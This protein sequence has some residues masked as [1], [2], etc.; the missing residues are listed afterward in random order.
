MSSKVA[1]ISKLLSANVLAQVI[2]MLIYPLLT[3]MYQPADF[4]LLNLFLTIANAI[5]IVSTMDLQYAIPLPKKNEGAFALVGAMVITLSII[6]SLTLITCF[7]CDKIALFFGVA[8]LEWAL[9]FLPIYIPVV[10]CWQVLSYIFNRD[11][12]YG[13]IATYQVVQSLSNAAL[14]VLLG[15][16]AVGGLALIDA[17]VIGPI[18]AISI[19]GPMKIWYVISHLRRLPSYL[20]KEYVVKYKDFPLYSMPKN[21]ICHL[22]NGLPVLMLTAEFGATNVGYYSL[23]ITIGYLPLIMIAS[24]IYQVMLRHTSERLNDNKPIYSEIQK[25]VIY[26]TLILCSV[27]FA[28]SFFLPTITE[29]LFGPGWGM[30]GSILTLLLPWF[31]TGFISNS[32]VFVPETLLKL[33]GNLIIEMSFIVLRILALAYGIWGMD[34]MNTIKLFCIV[35]FGIKMIQTGWFLWI[36]KEHDRKLVEKA[37]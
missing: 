24:S 8:E 27:F 10:G 2:G 23:A 30:T 32:L 37:D 18:I 36:A 15:M 1:N 22:S 17:S 33:K 13:K 3:R 31:V 12:Q 19:I 16:G 21:L 4:T 11:K 20:A 35:S 9:W 14:K 34:F 28:I 25:F 29:L 26:S 6:S 5:L 7:F